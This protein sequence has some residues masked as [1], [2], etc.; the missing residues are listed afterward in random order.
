M[1]A[2]RIESPPQSGPLSRANAALG[3]AAGIPAVRYAAL[4]VLA[5]LVVALPF[6]A[7]SNYIIRVG[8]T[9][10][11]Y[12]ILSL[13]LNIVVGYCGL[14]DLG[15]V[16]FYAL[17]AYVYAFL[18]SP[19]FGVHWPWFAV[20][21]I[22]IMVP[23]IFGVLLGIPV[24]RLRGDYLAIV[25][26]GFGEIIR[27][28]LN[29]LDRVTNGPKGIANLD[30]V[31]LFGFQ[32]STP[33]RY[34]YLVFFF[35]LLGIVAIRRLGRS[36]IGR[37]WGAIREDQEAAKAIGLNTHSLKLRAF[38]MGASF[39]GIAGILF[40]GFQGFVSPESFTF[41]E[42]VI[43]FCMITLGGMGSIPGA[44]L[45]SIILVLLPEVL[46]PIAD[47]RM[48]FY[49]LLLVLVMTQR[50]QGLWPSKQRR[51]ELVEADEAGREQ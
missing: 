30:K 2:E 47:Y 1:A 33:T 48:L 22:S 20:L 32:F 31:N 17:G 45:G 4:G 25:T 51:R 13:G 40:A 50:P 3:R 23:A 44:I 10:G 14:L 16:A 19:H 49:G 15:Y 26:L 42:S 36:R 34:Y 5:A 11:I 21:P 43:I 29:N 24:L 27:L 38:A 18:A 7:G 6:M 28:F 9:A 8:I 12:I 35:V 46:R 39:A 41:G 37:A